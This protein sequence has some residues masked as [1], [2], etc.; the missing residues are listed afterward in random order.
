[1]YLQK[2]Q[3]ADGATQLREALRLHP[4][5]GETEYN[6]AQALNQQGHGKEA[7]ALWPRLASA[8]PQDASAQFQYGCALA[9]QGKARDAM[10]QF[11]KALLLTPEYPEALDALAWILSTDPHPELRNG[12]EAV[13]MAEKACQLAGR[14]RPALFLTL[15][16]AYA[17]ACRFTEA[18]A[19]ARQG[20]ELAASQGQKEIETKAGRLL[21]ELQAGHPFREPL[22]TL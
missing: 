21:A 1:M 8:R 9:H 15:A 5:N 17:E 19:T 14:Q 22:D 2:G 10:S 12:S 7:L 13:A 20:R 11:A 18:V 16:A 3:L 4:G 6:L